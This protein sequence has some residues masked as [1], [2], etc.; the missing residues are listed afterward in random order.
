M[1]LQEVVKN[2]TKTYDVEGVDCIQMEPLD[3]RSDMGLLR[4]PNDERPTKMLRY[5]L[6]NIPSSESLLSSTI[7]HVTKLEKVAFEER[8]SFQDYLSL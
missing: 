1:E 5:A 2:I 7:A 4:M 8:L 6:S 3:L